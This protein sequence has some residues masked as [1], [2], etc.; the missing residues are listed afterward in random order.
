MNRNKALAVL[1]AMIMASAASCASGQ[2]EPLL[3]APPNEN[4]KLDYKNRKLL[5]T[6]P[7]LGGKPLIIDSM[8][9]YCKKGSTHR[10]WNETIIPQKNE[11]LVKS[12]H[13][14]KVKTTLASG[15]EVLHR[16][17]V[18]ADEILCQATFTNLTDKPVDLEWMQPCIRVG[19]F[20]GLSQ[21]DY[22]RKCFIFTKKGLTRLHKTNRTEQAIYKGGQVYVPANVD[23]NDVNPRP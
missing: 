2:P 20:T 7:L 16:F 12:P 4:V 14:I 13:E 19:D 17:A 11:I 18:V 22:Y 10:P 3:N 1:L 15:V 5:V 21:N 8:E 6:H 9:A 23:R